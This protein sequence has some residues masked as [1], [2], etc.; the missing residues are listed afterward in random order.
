MA[1]PG[2]VG[3]NLFGGFDS[4]TGTSPPNFG[5]AFVTLAPWDEREK[6]GQSLESI[7]AS[8]RPRLAAIQ[9]ARV[10]ALNPAP[11]RGLSRTGGFEFQLQDPGGGSVEELAAVTQAIV[12]KAN[13]SDEIDGAFSSFR[14][15]VPQ[16]FVDLDRT[17]ART[18]GVSVS[19]VF[20][21]LQAFMGGLYV[22]DFDRF[23]RLFRVY[24]QA[25]GDLRASPEDVKRL[26]VR[27]ER[28]EMIPLSTLVSLERITG[29]RDIPHYNLYRSAK[30][31]GQPA[32]GFSSGQALDRMEESRAP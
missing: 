8:V 22:N 5:S 15:N 6:E 9:G 10:I 11:I 20:E 27:S 16:V 18:L 4:L 25:E 19:D 14:P 13:E 32:P 17:K 1:T 28:G 12:Q 30:I 24:A 3:I 29:P 2:I 21:T 23:G 31:Q 7:F 26:W